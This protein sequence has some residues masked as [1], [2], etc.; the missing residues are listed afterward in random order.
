MSIVTTSQYTDLVTSEHQDKPNFMAVISVS[1]QPLVDGQNALNALPGDF[2]L[3][4]AVGAQLDAVGVRVGRTRYIETPLTGVYFTWDTAG[5]GWDQGYW[6]GQFDPVEGVTTLDDPTYRLLLRAVIAANSW[7][8]T[9]TGAA[10]ALANLFNGSTTP[11][12][13]IFIQDNQN[14]T[15]TFGISGQQPGAVFLALLASGDV[16]LKPVGVAVTYVM[17]S[18][19]NTPVFGWDVENQYISGWDVGSWSVPVPS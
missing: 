11:G 9:V 16:P 5:L 14:M 19:N 15:M 18:V 12:A 10:A 3:D 17:N 7:D 4:D 8:G 2:D 6:R 13:L 1:V